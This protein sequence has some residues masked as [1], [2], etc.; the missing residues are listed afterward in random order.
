MTMRTGEA[1]EMPAY[2]VFFLKEQPSV[3]RAFPPVGW[4]SMSAQLQMKRD[5]IYKNQKPEERLRKPTH[6]PQTTTVVAW[7]NTVVIL[8]QPGQ[9]TSMK[10]LFGPCAQ[11]SPE[12]TQNK[13]NIINKR[14]NQPEPNASSCGGSSLPSGQGARGRG[15]P[16]FARHELG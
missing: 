16:A 10:K 6:L 3:N 14:G 1:S 7:L 8:K 12:I 15:L 4:Q 5:S 13:Q 9:R 2:S 11:R